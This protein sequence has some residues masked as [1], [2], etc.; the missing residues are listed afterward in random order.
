MAVQLTPNVINIRP[1][2]VPRL[3]DEFKRQGIKDYN[4]WDGIYDRKTVQENINCAHKQIV[5]WAK[6]ECL[7]K[8]LIMED[9]ISFT[10]TKAF[11]YYLQNEPSDYDIYLGGIYLGIIKN[12][13]VDAFTGMHCYIVH[14]RFYD[15][16]LSTPTK[17]HVDHSLKGLGKY[18]VCDPFIAVQFNGWS[19]NSQKYCNYDVLL[20]NRKLYKNI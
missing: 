20:E 6:E 16:F 5:E 15:T 12:G 14:E 1:D 13:V 17:M 18:I 4:L 8:V 7:S 9:D 2:R 19:D 10:D 3:L 11:D